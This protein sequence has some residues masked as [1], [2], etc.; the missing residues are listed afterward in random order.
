MKLK[1]MAVMLLPLM[2][3]AAPRTVDEVIVDMM[4]N[5]RDNGLNPDPKIN[6][7][8]G[9]LWINWRYGTHPLQVNFKGSGEPDG[10]GDKPR[11]DVLTD[12]RYLHNLLLYKNLHPQD[13]RFDADLDRFRKIVRLEFVGSKNERGWLYDEFIDMYKLSGD[14]FYRGVARSL[15]ESYAAG[16]SK[17]P[18]PVNFKKN[19]NHPNG[20]YRVDNMLQQGAALLQA[21]HEFKKPEWESTGRKMIEFIYTHA[22]FKQYRCFAIIMDDLLTPGGKINPNETIYRDNHGRYLVDGG[23]VRLGGLGQIVSSLLHAYLA[24][25]DKVFL[26]RAIDMLDALS[27][28]ENFL[29]LWDKKNLGYFN[30]VVF[31]GKSQADPGT[32]RLSDAKKESGRQAHMLEAAVVANRLTHDRYRK[33]EDDLVTVT[34][35]KAYYAPGHG[36]LYEQPADWTLLPL[37]KG[38]KEDWVTTEAMGI[39]LMALQ[40][41]Q[42]KDPW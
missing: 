17:G 12:Q 37:K 20:Y 16:V 42:R 40:E 30:G 36:I 3:T 18:A 41:R 8:L 4:S 7:G 23:V 1:L 24:T 15:V 38:G 31:P 5:I 2:G 22:Y 32:P 13:T 9:G 28:Q 34:T 25:Q 10:P 35:E 27:P 14:E 11:H 19:P 29:G 33:L 39:T 21:A 26:D 6:D